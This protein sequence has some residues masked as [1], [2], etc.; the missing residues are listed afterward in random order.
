M[1]WYFHSNSPLGPLICTSWSQD[2]KEDRNVRIDYVS[3]S[4]LVFSV[5]YFQFEAHSALDTSDNVPVTF[6]KKDI[7]ISSDIVDD[8]YLCF[9]WFRT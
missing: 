8:L 3:H 5:G 9:V 7:L 1:R 4:L 6:D 2:Q